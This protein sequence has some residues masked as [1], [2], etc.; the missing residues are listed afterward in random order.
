MAKT[1][2]Y[3]IGGSLD[4]LDLA[5]RKQIVKMGLNLEGYCDLGWAEGYAIYGTLPK[6]KKFVF[7]RLRFLFFA[8]R[9]KY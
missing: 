1:Y 3:L 2:V 5:D 6:L 4:S 7:Q 9:R 8:F